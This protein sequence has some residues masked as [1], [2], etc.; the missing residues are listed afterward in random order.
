MLKF[1]WGFIEVDSEHVSWLE[2]EYYYDIEHL[3]E[4]LIIKWIVGWQDTSYQCFI[5]SSD[6]YISRK[7][8]F[9]MVELYLCTHQVTA[10]I[11]LKLL[12]PVIMVCP[13]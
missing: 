3:S 5:M 10:S 6:E 13:M 4:Y 1:L 7:V 11:G 12:F 9:L 8:S 2:S